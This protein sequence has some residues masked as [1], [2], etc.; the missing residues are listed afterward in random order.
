MKERIEGT[1]RSKDIFRSATSFIEVLE[2]Q[3]MSQQE[4]PTEAEATHLLLI[5][6]PD[7]VAQVIEQIQAL[8]KP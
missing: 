1:Q 5:K 3:E 2:R 6:K 7:D 4:E 8:S